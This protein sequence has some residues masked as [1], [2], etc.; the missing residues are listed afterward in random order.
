MVPASFL[1][2]AEKVHQRTV[3]PHGSFLASAEAGK[4]ASPYSILVEQERERYGLLSAR[5]RCESLVAFFAQVR[6]VTG[7]CDR[8]N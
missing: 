8:T 5:E 3:V 4:N 2:Y 1:A 6:N 7:F